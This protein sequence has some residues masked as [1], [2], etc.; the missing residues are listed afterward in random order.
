MPVELKF[1]VKYRVPPRIIYEALTDPSIISKYTQSTATFDKSQGGAFSFYDGF[2]TGV[3]EEIIEN[4]KIV[5]K[6]KFSSW[7]ENCDL[8]MTIKEKA[9]DECLIVVHLKNVPE[10]DANKQTVDLKTLEA[11]F[12]SQIF[13]KIS[14]FLGYPQNNDKSDSED[15]S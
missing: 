3:N 15:D 13:Q 6:Y 2:I 7:T 1:N 9:G 11:G 8:T 14:N 5:Q 4:K 12:R 10:R